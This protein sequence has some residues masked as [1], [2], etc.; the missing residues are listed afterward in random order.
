M[1]SNGPVS[2]KVVLKICKDVYFQTET[3][4]ELARSCNPEKKAEKE[5][6]GKE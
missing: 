3:G 5:E 6:E 4:S 1:R 2:Y